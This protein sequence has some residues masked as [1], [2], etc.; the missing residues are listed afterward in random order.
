M[1]IE[2]YYD[3]GNETDSTRLGGTDLKYGFAWCGLP[4][5][6]SHNAPNNSLGLLWAE[7]SKMRRCFHASP[8]TRT[9]YEG[10]A[11]SI[12]VARRGAVESELSF[13]RLFGPGM[14]EL[15]SMQQMWD[16]PQILRSAAGGGKT[17]LL[18]LFTPS[19]LLALHANRGHDD[20][21]ELYQRLAE[22]GIVDEDGSK[23]LG[24]LIPC[25][26]NYANLEDLEF[27]GAR[28]GRLFFGLLNARI[29]FSMLRAC[30]S[31]HSLTFPR[32]LD[33]LSL[34]E[35][36]EFLNGAGVVSL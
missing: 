27:D 3:A 23:A 32:D 24:V 26:R 16:R 1:I 11:E 20:V 33:R 10:T 5:V 6:L 8:G 19:V 18:K 35:G 22:F 9:A 30:L 15:L 36:T 21:K 12:S 29:V 2:K 25:N 4:V 13:L 7:G 17:S 14:L 31:L 34:R 28:K